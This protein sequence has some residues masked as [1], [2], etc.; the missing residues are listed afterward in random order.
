MVKTNQRRAWVWWVVLIAVL[1]VISSAA[2]IVGRVCSTLARPHQPARHHRRHLL[3]RPPQLRRPRRQ[4]STVAALP[5]AGSAV[6]YVQTTAAIYRIDLATGH[7]TQTFAPSTT[8]TPAYIA[9]KDWVL[10]K[11]HHQTGDDFLIRNNHLIR[12]LP[13]GLAGGV[14]YP[15][16]GPGDTVWLLPEIISDHMGPQTITLHRLD[17]TTVASA[18]LHL[19]ATTG[20]IFSDHTG[21]LLET[22][23][24]RI[25]LHTPTAVTQIAT[26]TLIADRTA[27]STD[28]ELRQPSPMRPAPA[29]PRHRPQH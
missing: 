24:G 20:Y 25:Y 15:E 9:R 28:L 6:V 7:T 19:P 16:P 18:T 3:L 23:A 27:P 26:G 8:T 10:C 2:V 29:R 1:A 5:G 14:G 13:A 4:P 17:G 11:V 12:P 21:N 22:T